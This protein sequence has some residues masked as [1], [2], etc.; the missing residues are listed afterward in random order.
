MYRVQTK[1][2][3]ELFLRWHRDVHGELPGQAPMPSE[4]TVSGAAVQ[5]RYI[6]DNAPARPAE[7]VVDELVEH[8]LNEYVPTGW[9]LVGYSEREATVRFVWRKD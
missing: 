1:S 7:P 9:A 8:Y 4:T 6:D 5:P 2:L 3:A